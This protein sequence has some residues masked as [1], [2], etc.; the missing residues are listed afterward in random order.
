MTQK[1]SPKQK[2]RKVPLL[3][4]NIGSFSD[5][6][7]L[8]ELS[9]TKKKIFKGLV[10]AIV[11]S[12][13]KELQVAEIFQINETNKVLLLE[14]DKWK[15]SLENAMEFYVAIEDYENGIKCRELINNI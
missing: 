9:E 3:N 4:Y 13:T 5:Y 14:K 10:E 12:N 15:R 2:K 6:E 11:H 1:P 7:V 8:T